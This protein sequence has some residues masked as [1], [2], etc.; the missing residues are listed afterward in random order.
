V[1]VSPTQELRP[2]ADENRAPDS[3]PRSGGVLRVAGSVDV[4][5]LDTASGYLT[6]TWALTRNVSRT[7]FNIRGAASFQDGVRLHPDIATDIP[8]VAN[9]GVNED[10]RTYVIHMRDG[11]L[12]DADP[13]REVT[14]EDVI[15][16]LKRLANPAQPCGGLAYY[17]DTIEGMAEFCAGYAMVDPASPAEMARY[18][19]SHDIAGLRADGA[20]TL[21]ITLRSP[22]SDFLRL[23]SLQFA[24]PAPAE[25]D[26]YVPDS[27]EFRRHTMSNGPYR[28]ASYLPGERHVLRR[29]PAWRPDRDP[30]RAQHVD[31]IE[32]D[33][34]YGSAEAVQEA[35][36]S[37]DADLSWDQRLP[38]ARIPE[39]LATG[40]ANLFLADEAMA[41]PYLVFNLAS[42]NNRGAL[43]DVRVRRAIGYAIDKAALADVFGGAAVAVPLH[44]VIP[45]GGFGHRPFAQHAADG[46][47]GDPA[48]ARQ[49]LSEAGYERE[50]T[51]RF[52]YRITGSN[53]KVADIIRSNLEACGITVQPVLDNDGSLYGRMLHSPADR[54]NGAWDIAAPGW[55]PDWYGNNGRSSIVPLFDGRS[56]GSNSPNYGGYDNPAVNRL[57]DQALQAVTEAE[58][59][60]YWHQADRRIMADLPIVPLLSQRYPLYRSDRVRNARYLPAVQAFEY[61]QIWLA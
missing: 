45:P 36:E 41:S 14:A 8:T 37:G 19:N 11:V 12:W 20:K 15:R 59:A 56:T 6:Q 39:L 32:L 28:I 40:S 49:L 3:T 27:P 31:G 54:R 57:I 33:L 2:T 18:Q 52:P 38:T 13:P 21:R 1:H 35:L 4:D 24:S 47:G 22:A 34:R 42:P 50:L 48:R 43:A 23:L 25:Y 30:I 51:L 46:D 9:G 5:H 26:R 53:P 55:V 61:N 44:Q 58:A 7:L 60:E 29:N 16:G 10:G 17:R